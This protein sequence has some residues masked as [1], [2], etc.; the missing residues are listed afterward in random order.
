MSSLVSALRVVMYLGRRDS[1]WDGIDR[2]KNIYK[3]KICVQVRQ[4]NR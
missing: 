2:K 4:S 1:H 3:G